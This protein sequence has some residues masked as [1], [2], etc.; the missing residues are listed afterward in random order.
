MEQ[1]LPEKADGPVL[2]EREG[3]NQ[4]AGSSL[5]HIVL[6]EHLLGVV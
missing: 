1:R 6:G 3:S 5:L 4:M 2:S